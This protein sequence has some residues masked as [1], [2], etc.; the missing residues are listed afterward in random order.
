VR[1]IFSPNQKRA[2]IV[3][4]LI[5]VGFMVVI[6]TGNKLLAQRTAMQRAQAG[7]QAL[8]SVSSG[9]LRMAN[10]LNYSGIT[11]AALIQSRQVPP[12]L[13]SGAAL[14]NPWGGKII[15][16]PKRV[17][18]RVNDGYMVC[19]TQVPRVECSLMIAP[20][21]QSFA[22]VSAEA[23]EDCPDAA[24][25]SVVRFIVKNQFEPIPVIPNTK[26]ITE[27]CGSET[28]TIVWIGT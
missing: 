6:F 10:G 28:N 3:F 12:N 20:T 18:G 21:A 24:T 16:S 22:I 1:L 4:P 15:V 14:I 23:S 9:V 13:I 19:M 26:N 7:Q 2:R 8:Q 27:A 25:V 17:N 11:S 5:L